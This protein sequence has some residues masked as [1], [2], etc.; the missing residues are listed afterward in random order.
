MDFRESMYAQFGHG[1]WV[2]G[3]LWKTG[4]KATHNA[5]NELSKLR[6]EKIL[7]VQDLIVLDEVWH[8]VGI[9]ET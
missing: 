6:V 7:R 1:V 8:H 2:W 4:E 9:P 3:A 5:V